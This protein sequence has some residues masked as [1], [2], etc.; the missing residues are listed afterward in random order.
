MLS[1]QVLAGDNQYECS[2]CLRNLLRE[3]PVEE[4]ASRP[5]KVLSDATKQLFVTRPSALLPLQLKRFSFDVLARKIDKRVTFPYTLSV[6]V[7]VC[8]VFFVD[9]SLMP[10]IF[11]FLQDAEADAVG[12]VAYELVGFVRHLG[13]SISSG[14]YVFYGCG[15]SRKW[16]HFNDDVLTTGKVVERTLFNDKVCIFRLS[17]YW[18]G[19]FVSPSMQSEHLGGT[20]SSEAYILLYARTGDAS[21]FVPRPRPAAARPVGVSQ[22]KYPQPPKPPAAAA[23]AALVG[24]LPADRATAPKIGVEPER[25]T[26]FFSPSGS[27]Q[28]EIAYVAACRGGLVGAVATAPYSK[29][30]VSSEHMK[31]LAEGKPV[32]IEA[33]RFVAETLQAEN[34]ELCSTRPPQP[35]AA[36]EAALCATGPTRL[37]RVLVLTNDIPIPVDGGLPAWGSSLIVDLREADV[38]VSLNLASV[39][40]HVWLP[41]VDLRGRALHF[42]DWIS[43]FLRPEAQQVASSMLRWVATIGQLL[44]V[45]DLQGA[46]TWPVFFHD[47]SGSGIRQGRP[48]PRGGFDVGTDGGVFSESA[49]ASIARGRRFA[50]NQ[51]YMPGLRRKIACTILFWRASKGESWCTASYMPALIPCL[52][53]FADPGWTPP[54]VAAVTTMSSAERSRLLALLVERGW[55]SLEPVLQAQP[56]LRVAPTR[57]VPAGAPRPTFLPAAVAPVATVPS[58]TAATAFALLTQPAAQLMTFFR[59]RVGLAYSEEDFVLHTQRIAPPGDHAVVARIPYTRHYVPDDDRESLRH[60]KYVKN[61][62]LNFIVLAKQVENVELCV[63]SP[64][65]PFGPADPALGPS[66]PTRLARALL[67]PSS[68]PFPN[69]SSNQLWQTPNFVDLRLLDIVCAIR[70]LG[71]NHY[72]YPMLDLW[73]R[74][75][76]FY[77][78]MKLPGGYCRREAIEHANDMLSWAETLGKLLE[79]PELYDARTWP[80]TWH[81]D[82]NALG[83]PTQGRP[84]PAT[85]TRAAGWNFGCDCAVFAGFGSDAAARGVRLDFSQ[86]DMPHGRRQ[87][88]FMLNNWWQSKREFL[89]SS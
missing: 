86:D 37:S 49:I 52:A 89:A 83:V 80:I 64:P 14:H 33:L 36:G 25:A 84:T 82:R 27:F 88:A 15:Q 47:G 40:G 60:G 42:Y 59:P 85:R 13:A 79:I 44:Q 34:V 51:A 75:L 31:T 62:V 35:F 38:V 3:L 58:P 7:Y 87:A 74:N 9:T 39:N 76:Q 10:L 61:M 70:H 12:N 23:A 2:S 22:I 32:A 8:T 67:I 81:E 24:P 1:T 50:F 6:P 54:P 46:S 21:G 48:K 30:A 71:G 66:G 4:G 72:A 55:G 77:D 17:C 63:A 43:D 19:R 16:T 18:R 26:L 65:M 73:G 56:A 45:P 68:A 57:P 28:S 29:N 69:A 20:A 53:L 5:I 78:S 41:A 11:I